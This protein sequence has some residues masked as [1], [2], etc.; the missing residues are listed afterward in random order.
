MD[1]LE[2]KSCLNSGSRPGPDVWTQSTAIGAADGN[3]VRMV[4]EWG[5]AHAGLRFRPKNGI[6][7]F[8]RT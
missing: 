8:N 3:G 1:V 2:Q 5:V 6:S 7:E 4:Q